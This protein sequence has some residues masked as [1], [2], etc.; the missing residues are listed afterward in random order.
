MQ[1]TGFLALLEA[2]FQNGI[3]GP[4]SKIIFFDV[5]F[6]TDE[7]DVPLVVLWL[8]VGAVYCTVRFQFVNL[9][10]FR[11]AI[12][13]VMGR[14]TRAGDTGEISHF[15]A[16]SAALSGTI[17]LGNIAGV[18][19]AV[20]IGGPGAVFWMVVAG[21][22]GMSSKFAEVTLAQCFRVR[23]KDGHWSGGPQ[24]Y[25]RDGLAQRGLPGLGRV[26]AP[27]FAVMCIGGSFG[28][29]NMFQANQTYALV[30]QVL[31]VFAGTAGKVAFG[32]LLAVLVGLVIV[33]GIRR[34][35][36]VA[37]GLVPFMCVLYMTAGFVILL[38]HADRLAESLMVIVRDAF[39]GEA[40][41]GGFVGV[42]I[43]GFRRAAFSNEAGCGS[44]PIVHSAA[45]TE[46]PVREGFVA[47]LE[48]FVDTVI[49]CTMTGLVLVVTGAYATPE[50]GTGIGMTSWAFATAFSWFPI[51][52]SLCAF[53][54]AY[55]T[56]I[57]WSY[58]GEQC[59][60]HLFG[61]RSILLYKLIFLVF[62][63]LGA[64]FQAQAVLEFGDMMILGMAFPNL[65]GVVLLSGVARKALDRYWQRL[66]AGEFVKRS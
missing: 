60:A 26:L 31:P 5:A 15:Q 7:A 39:T 32:F 36:E 9:R 20:G 45:R 52:L 12:D 40:A 56:M 57:S 3:V 19:V 35:G 6:W 44:S 53:L 4:L 49:V 55:A 43:Q 37:A 34:I 66:R 65:I 38:M 41:Q 14:Y 23:R 16:L 47:L 1:S 10:G 17:G 51:V 2:L 64:I 61:V 25:L 18:A 13:C 22:L 54:F 21:F 11:H 58:Y 24:H 28:G 33:G 30:A 29:G 59:W 62:T 50:A 8:I 27:I 42:L 46:E 48:P 63:W